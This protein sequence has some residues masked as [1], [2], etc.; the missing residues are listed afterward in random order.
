MSANKTISANFSPTV[1]VTR[2]EQTN[3]YLKYV[4][5][6][7]TGSGSSFS[8]GSYKYTNASN[9][10]VTIKFT[11][12]AVSYIARTATGY[13]NALVTLDGGTPEYVDLYSATTKYKVSVWS[14]ASLGAGTHT[15]VI[16]RSGTRGSGLGY[17]ICFDAVDVTGGALVDANSSGDTTYTLTTSVASGSGSITRNPNQS[18]YASGSTVTLTA[19][20]ATGYMFTGWSGDAS[21]TTNPLTVTMS[22]NKNIS[23][24]FAPSSGGVTRFEQSNPLLFFAGTWTTGSSTN[25]SGGSFANASQAGAKVTAVFTGTGISYIARTGPSLGLAKVTLDG[26]TP[27]Y[28]D[29]YSLTTKYRVSVWSAP[30]L[31]QGTHT[32]VIEYN[33][34]SG[35]GSGYTINLD[36]LDITDGSLVSG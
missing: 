13:G 22:A 21:G 23:A 16:A 1:S 12:S 20:P 7:T 25:Y 4:G 36:A 9:G 18:S 26:G 32:L 30:A 33:G 17:S 8:G 31:V 11:G 6:W 28:V 3:A 5:T 19:V 27:T 2:F 24:N 15:L 29:L 10:S 14:A 35:S 34:T